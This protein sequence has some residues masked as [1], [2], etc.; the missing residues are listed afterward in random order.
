MFH[1]HD[2]I[3]CFIVV[4]QL[5]LGFIKMFKRPNLQNIKKYTFCVI[6]SW[7]TG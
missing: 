2:N 5:S 1:I 6:Y 3:R 4:I 7:K